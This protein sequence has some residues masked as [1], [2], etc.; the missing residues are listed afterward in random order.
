MSIRLRTCPKSR[1]TP[2]H[3]AATIKP[4][5]STGGR[6]S[7][8]GSP[9]EFVLL[10]WPKNTRTRLTTE[11]QKDALPAP[12]RLASVSTIGLASYRASLERP[13]QSDS[14]TGLATAKLTT[15]VH[16][17][18]IK[19]RMRFGGCP[20]VDRCHQ[21]RH[22]SPAKRINGISA[23]LPRDPHLWAIMAPIPLACIANTAIE[24][25]MLILAK[26]AVSALTVVLVFRFATSSARW[27][28]SNTLVLAKR[29]L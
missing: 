9:F 15:R 3:Q 24:L 25:A 8:L 29:A 17:S 16:S 19:N 7:T 11:T 27:K 14:R 5:K 13:R 4:R 28:L 21:Q 2:T 22:S 12:H 26:K 23:R 10:V 18:S 20:F 1:L 6:P